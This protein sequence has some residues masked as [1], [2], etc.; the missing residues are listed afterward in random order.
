[1]IP[2]L[3]I[4]SAYKYAA[5]GLAI[6]ALAGSAYLKGRSDV[7]ALWNAERA[8]NALLAAKAEASNRQTEKAWLELTNKAEVE[9]AETLRI[10]TARVAT[11]RQRLRDSAATSRRV[12]EV[13]GTTRSGQSCPKCA[14]RTELLG[15][16]ETLIGLAESADRERAGMMACAGAWPK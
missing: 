11:E 8:A 3:A 7:H 16:G 12:S 15:I 4:P 14:T 10:T 9:Y 5:I 6:V 1:M 13:T 2:L